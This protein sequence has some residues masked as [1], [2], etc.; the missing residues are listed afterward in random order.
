MIRFLGLNRLAFGL[1]VA[2]LSLPGCCT[3]LIES[4]RFESPLPYHA[5]PTPCACRNLFE[6]ALLFARS[7]HTPLPGSDLDSRGIVP[8]AGPD[9]ILPPHSKFHPV[10]TRPVFA[11]RSEYPPPQPLDS[12]LQ[13]VPTPAE[14]LPP[15]S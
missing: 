9:S 10:P 3:P 11:P 12:R 13:P 5:G 2:I 8:P 14:Q 7:P 1:G 6:H 15:V 4:R